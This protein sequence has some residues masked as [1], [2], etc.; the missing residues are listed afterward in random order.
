MT[1]EEFSDWLEELVVEGRLT[2]AA[3]ADLREQRERF[4]GE[5]D[6]FVAH[7]VEFDQRVVGFQAGELLVAESVGELMRRARERNPG[8]LVYFEGIG[9]DPF[10]GA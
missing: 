6:D 10:G 5:R 7:D 8:R 9:H 2:R 4:D 3:A 1:F